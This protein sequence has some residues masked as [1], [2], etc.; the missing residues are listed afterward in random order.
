[1]PPDRR[2]LPRAERHSRAGELATRHDGVAHRRD[3]RGV[4]VTRADVRSEVEAGR[5]L[6]AGRHTVVIGNVRPSGRA[7]LWRAVWESGAGAVLDGPSALVAGGLTG[8]EAAMIDVSLP[9]ANRNHRV[10]G[11][12]RHRRTVMPPA[13]AAGLPRVEVAA[14]AV[15]AGAWAASDR[16]AALVLSLVLQQRLTTPDRLREAWRGG[17]TR[18]ERS[19][20][21]MLT[22][23]VTDL[24][25]GAHSLG[26]LDFADLCR[27]EGLPAPTRQVV[28]TLPGGRVYLDVAWED[29]GLVVEIDGGHHALALNVVDDALRQNEVVLREHRVLRLPV[30]GLRLMPDQFLAQIVR[31]HRALARRAA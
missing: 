2:R 30:L 17:A 16:Q 3:L 9:R 1:M 21:R 22:A 13:R 11:V 7:L 18:I 12:R 25:D 26:E 4:G 6:T 5:W 27:G 24:C 8:F 28:R 31:A 19:R 23:V 15:H 10:D 14:A 29:V 20:R